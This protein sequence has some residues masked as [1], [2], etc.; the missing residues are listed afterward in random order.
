MVNTYVL[1]ILLTFG[2]LITLAVAALLVY[3][4]TQKVRAEALGSDKCVV[5]IE[6]GEDVEVAHGKAYNFDPEGITYRYH[7]RKNT[8]DVLV[9]EDYK[10]SWTNGRRRI[11]L[12][13]PGDFIA[14]P[15]S[16]DKPKKQWS[17]EA[18]TAAIK[19]HLAV[20]IV[21][22]V[23]GANKANWLKMGLVVTVII[24][25][26]FFVFNMMNDNRKVSTPAVTPAV[27]AQ[28]NPSSQIKVTK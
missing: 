16:S 22:S 3:K 28:A 21:N 25:A 13:S 14:A 1:I 27:E 24:I 8:L 11:R 10:W 7:W 20:Q 17:S 5:Y 2:I 6:I 9:P 4:W 26:G 19:S 23:E 18:I 12:A 15:W